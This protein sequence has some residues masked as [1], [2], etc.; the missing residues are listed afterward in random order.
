MVKLFL[1]DECPAQ[2]GVVSD[3]RL[4]LKTSHMMRQNEVELDDMPPGFEANRFSN[5]SKKIL[6]VAQVKWSCPPKFV[7]NQ[8]FQVASGEE[9]VQRVVQPEREHRILEAIYIRLSSIP[10]S[11]SVSVDV[12]ERDYDD[13][14]TPVVPIIP[15]EEEEE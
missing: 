7:L 6:P 14:L 5:S 11:P 8:N 1:P 4:Q 12:E 15:I 2:V 9:S 13:R 10:P 3:N